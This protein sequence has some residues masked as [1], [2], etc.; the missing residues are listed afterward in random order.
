MSKHQAFGG[1]LPDDGFELPDPNESQWS[2]EAETLHSDGYE[3]DMGP[4][5]LEDDPEAE[6]AQIGT[7]D[8][9]F[10]DPSELDPFV[11]RDTAYEWHGGQSSPLYAFASSGIIESPE[12]LLGEIGDCIEAVSGNPDK[13]APDDLDKLE[14][15]QA[16]VMQKAHTASNHTA[17]NLSTAVVRQALTVLKNEIL[18]KLI[19]SQDPALRSFQSRIRTIGGRLSFAVTNMDDEDVFT[20]VQA[21]H[22]QALVKAVLHLRN[23]VRTGTITLAD[24]PDNPDKDLA[25][26]EGGLGTIV[27]ACVVRLRRDFPTLSKFMGKQGQKRKVAMTQE[28]FIEDAP[29][30]L[31][32]PGK[33]PDTV[34]FFDNREIMR[35][36][37]SQFFESAVLIADDGTFYQVL[38][39]VM[40]SGNFVAMMQDVLHPQIVFTIS[41]NDLVAHTW[42]W[43][44]PFDVVVNPELAPKTLTSVSDI[45]SV[46]DL[47]K[48]VIPDTWLSY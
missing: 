4:G 42:K 32:A 36:F 7:E 39:L 1:N 11:A 10:F 35:K 48:P 27:T 43:V 5:Y 14:N 18:P 21:Q 41:V 38:Q 25:D 3:E 16:V 15:L 9:Y 26:I 13:Y 6:E 30:I 37:Y 8:Y 46:G 45:L 33:D 24:M 28:N 12:A 34:N 20:G 19:N 29:K 40:T 44:S 23:A 2:E 47:D 22:L 17:S 31:G